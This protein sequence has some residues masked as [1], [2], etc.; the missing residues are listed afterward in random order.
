M[1]EEGGLTFCVLLP[2]QG[3]TSVIFES[4]QKKTVDDHGHCLSECDLERTEVADAD[5]A[6]DE[7][8]RKGCCRCTSMNYQ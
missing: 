7:V 1:T 8:T 3:L 5:I 6:V 4:G 2:Q